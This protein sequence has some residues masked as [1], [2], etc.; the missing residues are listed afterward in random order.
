MT[1]PPGRTRDTLARLIRSAPETHTVEGSEELAD[2]ILQVTEGPEIRE[3]R[4][5]LRPVRSETVQVSAVAERLRQIEETHRIG[6]DQPSRRRRIMRAVLD[7]AEEYGVRIVRRAL[8]EL[9]DSRSD[10]ERPH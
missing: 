9:I 7:A 10:G 8:E 3:V 1:R 2:R 4:P 5:R 6:D